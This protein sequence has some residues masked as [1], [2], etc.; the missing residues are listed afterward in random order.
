M[1][2]EFSV[3]PMQWEHA[4]DDRKTVV[5]AL[6][7][8][9][10][11]YRLGPLSITVEGSWEQLMEALRQCHQAAARDHAR[12]VTRLVIDDRKSQP[13]TLVDMFSEFE[14]ERRAGTAARASLP[15]AIDDVEEASI[16]SFPASDAPAWTPITRS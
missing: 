13:H 10:V 11:A 15:L 5:D 14:M 12:V 1:L 4:D 3:Y 16:E 9:G 8:A 6:E 2:A 7:R